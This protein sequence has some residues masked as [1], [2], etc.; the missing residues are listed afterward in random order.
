VDP[1][2][3]PG[4]RVANKKHDK[5]RPDP[6]IPVFVSTHDLEPH[7]VEKVSISFAPKRADAAVV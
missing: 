4:T 7:L 3:G 6:E 1:D 5:N 2:R